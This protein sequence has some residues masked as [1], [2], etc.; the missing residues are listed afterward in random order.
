MVSDLRRQILIKSLTTR[1]LVLKLQAWRSG[2]L[3]TA[4]EMKNINTASPTEQMSHSE[5]LQGKEK[6]SEFILQ[7]EFCSQNR[8]GNNLLE[9]VRN[10][11]H[12]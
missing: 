12:S 10:F 4:T 7:N 3:G 9:K 2:Q 5:N 8:E 11:K 1:V 6:T